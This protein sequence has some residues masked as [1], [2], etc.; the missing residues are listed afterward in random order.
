MCLGARDLD[1]IDNIRSSAG[2]GRGRDDGDSNLALRAGAVRQG[3]V[4]DPGAVPETGFSAKPFVHCS[5]SAS[6]RRA[7][8]TSRRR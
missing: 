8:R 4:I 7:E 6:S 2:A 3:G 1:A 5:T